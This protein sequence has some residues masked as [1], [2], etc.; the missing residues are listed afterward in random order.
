ML[1]KSF[2]K[3]FSNPVKEIEKGG[4]VP[5]FSLVTPNEN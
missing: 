5:P 2:I 3:K 1:R 4:L